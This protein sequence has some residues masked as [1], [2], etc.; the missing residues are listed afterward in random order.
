MFTLGWSSTGFCVIIYSALT[1][2]KHERYQILGWN[3]MQQDAQKRKEFSFFLL[4]FVCAFCEI[5]KN[6]S[7]VPYLD[8]NIFDKTPFTW[9]RRLYIIWSASPPGPSPRTPTV[10]PSIPT[11]VA[12]LL[13][14]SETLYTLLF[15]PGISVPPPYS[16]VIHFKIFPDGTFP[17]VIWIFLCSSSAIKT[18]MTLVLISIGKWRANTILGSRRKWLGTTSAWQKEKMK[19]RSLRGRWKPSLYNPPR[20]PQSQTGRLGEMEEVVTVNTCK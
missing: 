2:W 12:L 6:H 14:T 16:R 10:P 3:K 5:R 15:L 20:K 1:A 18:N 8:I 19:K 11:K 17:C 7:Q 9:S 13:P 4:L